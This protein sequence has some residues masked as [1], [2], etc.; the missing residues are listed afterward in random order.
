MLVFDLVVDSLMGQ[1]IFAKE[2]NDMLSDEAVLSL[3]FALLFW[4]IA[5]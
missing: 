5:C 3:D 1:S 4:H 2:G